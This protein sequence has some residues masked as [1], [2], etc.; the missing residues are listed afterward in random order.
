MYTTDIIACKFVL[1]ERFL[2]FNA[3]FTYSPFRTVNAISAWDCANQTANNNSLAFC[4]NPNVNKCQ[5]FIKL[6][7]Y[8]VAK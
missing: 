4:Y 1:S 6:G 5:I 2:Y 8:L 7:K 3:A